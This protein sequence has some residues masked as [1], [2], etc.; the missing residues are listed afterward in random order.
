MPTMR[1]LLAALLCAGLG[2]I[3]V[4]LTGDTCFPETF[5][6]DSVVC[7]C[8][9][10]SCGNIGKVEPENGRAIVYRSSMAGLRFHPVAVEFD[11]PSAGSNDTNAIDTDLT[12]SVNANQTLQKI[13]GFGGAFT[14][15]AAINW[16]SLHA[17]LRKRLLEAYYG[18]N[19]LEY[20]MGRINMAGCD[21]STRDYT[22][23]DSLDDF[24]LGNF[25]LAVEDTDYKIPMITAASRLAPE[26]I[27]Y[28]GSPWSAPGWMKTN[29]RTHGP[30]GIKG[31]PGGKYYKTWAQY[32]VKFYN[33]YKARGVNLWGFTIQNE[34]TTGFLPW[35]WQTMAMSPYTQRDFVKKDLGP[36]LFGA[37]NDS[38]NIMILDDN[39]V[40]LPWWANVV[41]NDPDA[42]KYVAGVGVH[43]YLDGIRSAKVL[44][45]TLNAHPDKFI[46]NTEACEGFQP[47]SHNVVLGR[48]ERAE[49]Y[50][51]SILNDL[52]HSVA[53]WV[54]WNLCLDLTGGPNWV[55][56][57]VDS[58]IIVNKDKQAF[59]KQ[60]MYY[61]LAHFTKFIPRGSF[62]LNDELQT[63]VGKISG[64]AFQRPDGY[65]SAVFVNTGNNER[66]IFVK[67][68]SGP[69][70]RFKI[71]PRTIASSIW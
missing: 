53:G 65:K 61:A 43:W 41:L 19:G 39:R 6:S 35:G 57:F 29:G 17:P 70:F 8:N 56:N 23:D 71:G 48:W 47:L 30:G 44:D 18:P 21:F 42:N 33:A 46:L 7:V 1:Q 52:R 31:S 26:E 2:S 64:V 66:T 13:I 32:F 3:C 37:A 69:Q 58:P 20:N 50:A 12:I 54:D 36:A 4:A 55:K 9:S 49:S 67:D 10:T 40:M 68:D 14:D 15:A 16:M 63:S 60:P 62:R 25:T 59:Y 28:F 34:P 5:N 38:I 22:Y 11:G 24:E 45:Q 27:Y 51:N